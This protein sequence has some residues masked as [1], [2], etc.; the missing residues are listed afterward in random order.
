MYFFQKSSRLTEIVSENEYRNLVRLAADATIFNDWPWLFTCCKYS[1]ADRHHFITC[2]TK[3]DNEL[4][5]FI[6]LGIRSEKIYCIPVKVGRFLQYPYGDRMG[7]LIHPDHP[8][9]WEVLLQG[10]KEDCGSS[11]DLLILD[12][13]TDTRGLRDK[14]LSWAEDENQSIY[15]R[16]TCN[17]PVVSIEGYTG[18]E[19]I[20]RSGGKK[21]RNLRRFIK[22][23]DQLNHTV[24]HE[25][26]EVTMVDGL[27]EDIT[28]TELESWKGDKQLG[29]F[30][31]PECADFFRE[32]SYALAEDNQLMVSRIYTENEL[33]TYRYGLFFRGVFLDYSIAYLPK[34]R[35][36]APG[37]VLL[38]SLIHY[39]VANGYKAIDASRVA[40]KSNNPI[41][42]W[43]DTIVV[44]HRAYWFCNTI[45]GRVMRPVI[46]HIKPKA[47]QFR[48][49][50]Q[51]WKNKE[52]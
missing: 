16:E 48:E 15:F 35:K 13:W 17:C 19:V 45:R 14:A 3:G 6:A 18:E 12:E 49:K 29:I 8:N 26:V 52:S 46:K 33:M 4:V 30:A 2:R 37:A 1:E 27:L 47:R 51:S 28:A 41:G 23:L 11:W 36:L 10:I 50:Y 5:A 34:Y 40:Q 39:A 7:I 44:H 22:R 31:H 21:R 38:E 20:A 24:S 43:A 32:V 25:K 42:W 9:S